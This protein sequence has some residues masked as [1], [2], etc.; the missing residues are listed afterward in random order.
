MF[1]HKICELALI[2]MVVV[3]V[4]MMIVH[5]STIVVKHGP[6]GYIVRGDL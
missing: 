4:A 6:C 3:L 2:A 1:M 5:K